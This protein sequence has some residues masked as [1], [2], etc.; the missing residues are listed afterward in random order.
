MP[1]LKVLAFDGLVPR[2]SPTMLGEAQAQIADNV[3]LTSQELRAWR[4]PTFVQGTAI[5]PQTIYKLYG[6]GSPLWLSWPTEVDVVPGPL[7]DTTESRIYLTGAAAY[8]QKTN[9]ALAEVGTY[10]RM[11]VPAPTTKPTVVASGGTGSTET[12]AYVYT[13]VAT[14]GAVQEESAPSPASDLITVLTGGTVSVSSFAVAPAGY[15]ITSRR[16]YRTVTG[17]TTDSYQF[18]AEIPV[19]TTSY[20]DSLPFAELGEVIATI[21][22]N[23][24]P[25]D[26]KGLIA[27]PG[28]YLAGFVGNTIYFSEPYYPHAWPVRYALSVAFPI[29]GLAAYGSSIAVMTDKNP[30]IINGSAPG[31]LSLEQLPMEE[32]CLSKSSI[33]S[34]EQGVIYASPNGLIGIGSGARGNLT[35]D[36]FTRDEWQALTPGLMHGAVYGGQYF[37]IFPNLD[38]GEALVLNR[39]DRPALCNIELNATAV[40]VDAREGKL[41]YAAAADGDIYL[42]DSDDVRPLTYVW[43]SK[44]FVFP[45]PTSFSVVRMDADFDQLLDPGLYNAIVAEIAAEN[46]VAWASPLLGEINATPM[47][48]HDINGSTMQNLPTLAGA[49]SVQLLVYADGELKVTMDLQSMHPVRLPAFKSRAIEFELSGNIDVRSITFATTVPELYV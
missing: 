7:A 43:R 48:T 49:R 18:V 1:A 23:P 37:G 33:A 24:P 19:A 29:K 32:P 36:L 30:Y 16:I 15:N 44:R 12:R 9:R 10:Y 14:F 21:G 38:D 8:P 35:R 25:D 4:G 27:L 28:G 34:D 26:L 41:Y 46:A 45:Q 2:T 11:G 39:D 47:N 17:A 42:A 20:A 3:K 5:T 6:G 40:H 22:W 13:H 31:F